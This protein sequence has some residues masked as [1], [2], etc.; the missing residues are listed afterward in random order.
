MSEAHLSPSELVQWRD[1]GV[2]DRE[3]IVAHIAAC[4][5]CRRAAAD[6][7]RE[8]PAEAAAARFDAQ[9]FV[10]AGYRAGWRGRRAPWTTR[11]ASLAAAAAIVLAVILV[12]WF[13]RDRTDS[14]LRGG[15]ARVALVRP[16][17]VEIR[18]PDLA[19]EWKAEAGVD[20]IRLTVIAIDAPAK[21][22]IDREVT[23]SRYVPTDDE[24]GRLPAGQPLHWF[25]DYRDAS[26]ATGTTPATRF[27]VR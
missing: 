10:P 3:R 27:S 19:F 24:R 9:D 6:L 5:V 8:R 17:D 18:T 16:V 7:E 26:G 14:T 23:G 4:A 1:A 25:I 13:L 2:G 20:R 21:P 15:D 12:P 22:L 11:A